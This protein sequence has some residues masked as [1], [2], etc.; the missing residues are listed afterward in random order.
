MARHLRVEFP[1]AIYHVTCRM[2]GDGRLENS[3]LFTEDAERV[4]FLERLGERVEEYNIRLYQ[5]VLMTNH[6][7]SAECVPRDRAR[8]EEIE[9]AQ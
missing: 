2:I 6:L 8:K 7:L 5:F 9:T 3:R 4:R 1:G